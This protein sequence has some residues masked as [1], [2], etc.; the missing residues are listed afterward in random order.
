MTKG[1]QFV[2]DLLQTGL[3]TALAVVALPDISFAAGDLKNTVNT[4]TTQTGGFPML[5]SSI[6]YIGGLAMMAGGAL[7]LKAHAENP[8]QTP[9]AH[10]VSRLLV[11]GA[12]ASLPAISGWVTGSAALNGDMVS[13][14]SLTTW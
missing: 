13:R 6:C 4:I 8:G 7:K 3:L 5:I 10:G 14:G 1:K 11:G 2:S 9:I 12:I